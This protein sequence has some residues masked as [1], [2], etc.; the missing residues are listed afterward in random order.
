MKRNLILCNLCELT[1]NLCIKLVIIKKLYYDA[2]PTKYQDRYTSLYTN[3]FIENSSVVYQLWT[4]DLCY[5][6]YQLLHTKQL[7][8]KLVNSIYLCICCISLLVHIYPVNSITIYVCTEYISVCS[9]VSQT[10]QRRLME[11]VSV[12]C[13]DCV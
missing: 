9:R 4:F 3:Y 12:S 7:V 6:F 11:V 2:W 8:S 1:R 10:S 5:P 13:S